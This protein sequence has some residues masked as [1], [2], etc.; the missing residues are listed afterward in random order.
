MRI[1]HTADWHLGRTLEGRSRQE[2]HAQ[3]V[4]ELCAIVREEAIDL[5][6]IAGDVFDTV[7]PSASAEELWCDALA[8]LG[9]NGRRAVV[10]IAGNHDSPDRLTAVRALAQRHG[11]TLFGYPHDDPGTHT[12]GPD[13]VQRVASGPGWVELTVPGVEHA[14]VVLALAY[15]SES[16][17]KQLMADTLGEEELQLAYADQVKRWLAAAASRFRPDAVRLITSHIYMAGGAET[18][19]VERPIQMGGA[20]T[21]PA[22]AVPA[23]AQYVAL[24]HLHRPQWIHGA[25]ALTR[26]S[27]SPLSFSFNEVGYQKGVTVLDVR[28]G[29][30][31]PAVREIPIS[32]GRPLVKWEARGL[33]EV[34]RWVAEEKDPTAF[35][36]LTV[37]LEHPLT[38]EQIHR[39]RALRPDI[40]HIHPVLPAAAE[41]AATAEPLELSIAEQFVRFYQQERGGSPPDA[42]VRLFLE[43][44]NDGAEEEGAE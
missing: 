3:F 19:D 15:P 11:A 32:V 29:D 44:V 17:L 24:G 22:D 13:R 39:L 12:P 27:G 28:P 1:L 26:Y 2:E 4:D 6:L 35:I 31:H 9:E 16:R 23:G 18:S 33:A 5:V 10:A 41:V 8:R 40:I 21:V 42:L 25:A 43:L 34:E 20:Y 37:H 36:D 30:A 14:A 7:N 38:L